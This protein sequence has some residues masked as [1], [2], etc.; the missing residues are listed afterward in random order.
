MNEIKIFKV[1]WNVEL[2]SSVAEV[3]ETFLHFTQSHSRNMRCKSARKVLGQ[4]FSTI[5]SYMH[6]SSIFQNIIK[7]Y[8]QT[9]Y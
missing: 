1:C 5:Q 7:I 9:L 8:F 2:L 3:K 6:R 4:G